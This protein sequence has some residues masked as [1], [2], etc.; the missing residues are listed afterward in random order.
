MDAD[1]GAIQARPEN[2]DRAIRAGR[3]HV[4]NLGALA[5]LQHA[6]VI[7]YQGH[8]TALTTFQSPSGAGCSSEPGVMGKAAISLPLSRTSSI[9]V[10]V[11]T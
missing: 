7:A 8:G 6:L 3:K 5:T 2:A 4:V 10:F 1:A 9:R 11:S